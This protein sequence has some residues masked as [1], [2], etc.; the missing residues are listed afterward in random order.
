MVAL[1]F[2]TTG[3]RRALQYRRPSRS[4][5]RSPFSSRAR[6]PDD[7]PF[8][9]YTPDE[10]TQIFLAGGAQAEDL[11]AAQLEWKAP[12]RLASSCLL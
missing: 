2:L 5:V 11:R 10:L 3:D 6:M 8:K 12:P 1:F 7:E 4:I 9:R